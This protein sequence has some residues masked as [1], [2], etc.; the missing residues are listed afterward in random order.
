VFTFLVQA[1]LM[2]ELR[3]SEPDSCRFDFHAMSSSRPMLYQDSG[4]A[5]QRISAPGQSIDEMRRLVNSD[6]GIPLAS[7]SRQVYTT[8]LSYG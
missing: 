1:D 6:T 3:L 7:T 8:I 4:S 2:A 5:E